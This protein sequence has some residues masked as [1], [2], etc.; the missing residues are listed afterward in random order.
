[1]LSSRVLQARGRI[2]EVLGRV[3]GDAAG[4]VQGEDGQAV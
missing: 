3:D 2:C 1:M 4:V